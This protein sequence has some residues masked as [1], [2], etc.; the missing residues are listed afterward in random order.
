MLQILND[1]GEEKIIQVSSFSPGRSGERVFVIDPNKDLVPANPE[2]M[3]VTG[4]PIKWMILPD[5]IESAILLSESE[6]TN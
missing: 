2:S 1:E 6:Q 5:V 3:I 4:M